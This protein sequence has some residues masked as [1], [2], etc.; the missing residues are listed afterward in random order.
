M[1]C[2][3]VLR[4]RSRALKVFRADPFNLISPQS[5]CREAVPRVHDRDYGSAGTPCAR[6]QLPIFRMT[7]YR[8][9]TMRGHPRRVCAH[10]RASTRDPTAK[11][12]A[13]KWLRVRASLSVLVKIHSK[14]SGEQLR[15]L[16]VYTHSQKF[17]TIRISILRDITKILKKSIILLKSKTYILHNA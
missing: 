17:N 3:H 7:H 5:I 8:G 9:S 12:S 2:A 16:Y 10:D 6:F 4:S 11:S 14:I 15:K 1:F 13:Q